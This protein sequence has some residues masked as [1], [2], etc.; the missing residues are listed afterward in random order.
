MLSNWYKRERARK[1]APHLLRNI[2]LMTAVGT[3]AIL[4]TRWPFTQVDGL[5]SEDQAN[6]I[7]A[8]LVMIA[9]PAFAFAVW[10][11]YRL[12]TLAEEAQ[13]SVWGLLMATATE[14]ESQ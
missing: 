8:A 12:Y 9:A 2:V 10:C 11:G 14:E 7:I 6:L 1:A 3:I 4:C 13:L 5:L